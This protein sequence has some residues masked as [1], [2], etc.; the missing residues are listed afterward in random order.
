MHS[1]S[2]PSA[3]PEEQSG[4]AVPAGEPVSPE[5]AEAIARAIVLR[6]LTMAARTRQ[7]LRTTLLKREVTP[8]IAE[9]VLDR[10]EAVG[11]VNDEAYATDYVAQRRASRG[12]GRRA[13]A[14]ELSRKG[15]AP[16]L[17]EQSL[18]DI[19][20]QDERALAT[21]LVRRKWRRVAGL[22][23][24][25]RRRRLA[26]MLGRRGYPPGLV[27]EVIREVEAEEGQEQS[28]AADYSAIVDTGSDDD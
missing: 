26:S 25:A 28:D 4:G 9:R 11:L 5:E 10:M 17:I 14:Q 16:E 27:F 6:Q 7:Q 12:S 19:E 23:S 20:S 1:I 18:A 3:N 13:L 24:R 8:D 21:D 15:I 2:E 22:E